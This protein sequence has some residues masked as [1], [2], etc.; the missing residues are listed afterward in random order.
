MLVMNKDAVIINAA[1]IYRSVLFVEAQL[2]FDAHNAHLLVCCVKRVMKG[3]MK[4]H[5]FMTDKH[6]L[7]VILS[8]FHLPLPLMSLCNPKP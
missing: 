3:S 7:E 5:H 4:F 8:Q 1:I 6:G 2:I